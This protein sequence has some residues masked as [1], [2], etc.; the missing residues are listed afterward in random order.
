M[1]AIHRL[2]IG[3][4]HFDADGFCALGQ[5][6]ADALPRQRRLTREGALHTVSELDLFVALDLAN[7]RLAEVIGLLDGLGRSEQA[8]HQA[9]EDETSFFHIMCD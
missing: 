2:E 8:D 6:E 7:A 9:N 3:E 4:L 5:H 1:A